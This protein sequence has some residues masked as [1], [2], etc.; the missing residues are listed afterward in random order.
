MNRIYTI[1]VVPL[2]LIISLPIFG[3]A[4]YKAFKIGKP[5]MED[6]EMQVY[7]LDSEANAVILFD[8]GVTRF[9]GSAG[10]LELLFRHHQVVKIINKDGFD[11]ATFEIP[12][13]HDDG[14]FEKMSK[15]EAYTY[16]LEGN[17]IERTELKSKEIFSEEVGDNLK[18]T[19]F[20]MPNVKEGSVI[21][22]IYSL[23]SDFVTHLR[24]WQFQHSIPSRLSQYRVVIPEYFAYKVMHS[25]YL[26]FTSFGNKETTESYYFNS[27]NETRVK[28]MDSHWAISDIP[29]FRSEPYMTTRRDYLSR[30]DFELARVTFPERAPREYMMDWKGFNAYMLESVYLGKHLRKTNQWSDLAEELATG[31]GTD[32]EK[33]MAICQHVRKRMEW[34]GDKGYGTEGNL[35]KVYENRS[36]SG[37]EINLILLSL[38]REAGMEVSPVLLST[39]DHGKTIKDLPLASIFNYM[40][41]RWNTGEEDVSWMPLTLVVNLGNCH[42][43]ASTGKALPSIRNLGDG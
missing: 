14:Q 11:H 6:M 5:P 30:V 33:A 43:F 2:F 41:V 10:G 15:I 21:E 28:A 36:G 7:P 35:R 42:C 25:G 23:R 22:L 37:A 20:T 16:N 29:A 19:K 38:L 32:R 40:V 26:S 1:F 3:H 13:Y 9:V 8:A 27:S 39:R 12:L 17:K 18:L 34:D 24:T 31:L 4:Q